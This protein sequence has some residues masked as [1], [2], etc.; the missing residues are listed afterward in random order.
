[1]DFMV[2]LTTSRAPSAAAATMA[3]GPIAAYRDAA[4]RAGKQWQLGQNLTVGIF[5]HLA[6][7]RASRRSRR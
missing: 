5:F 7:T 4:A 6:R 3:E 2:K 1:M